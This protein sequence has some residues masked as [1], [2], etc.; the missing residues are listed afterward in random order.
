M[1]TAKKLSNGE[2]YFKGKLVLIDDKKLCSGCKEWK[3]L[4]EYSVNHYRNGKPMSKCRECMR[5]YSEAQRIR[6]PKSK[7][8]W[9]YKTAAKSRGLVFNLSKEEFL[10]FWQK[11]CVYCNGEIPTIGL[12]REDNTG[13]YLL[14]NV[15]SCCIICNKMK[16]ALPYEVFIE[17]C[18]KIINN[19]KL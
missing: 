13:G 8:Y 3:D 11:P 16:M 7:R 17:H 5:V 10:T 12:D 4:A 19:I 15:V 18:K 6:N 14:D 9:D 2:N 1:K